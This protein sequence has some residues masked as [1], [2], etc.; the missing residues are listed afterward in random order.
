M[1]STTKLRHM[2]LVPEEFVLIEIISGVMRMEGVLVLQKSY[3]QESH[4]TVLNLG[5][6]RFSKS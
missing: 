1:R 6:T 5:F 3:E 4:H 2:S